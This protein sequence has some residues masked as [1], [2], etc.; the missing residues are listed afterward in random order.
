MLDGGWV[1]LRSF[2]RWHQQSTRAG[3]L[4]GQ[5]LKVV[6]PLLG[7][8]ASSSDHACVVEWVKDALDPVEDVPLDP[9]P[10]RHGH[11]QRAPIRAERVERVEAGMEV[12]DRYQPAWV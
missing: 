9:R 6:G 8:E 7:I 1:T 4:V 5:A 12:G 11:D 2:K 3:A 10:L